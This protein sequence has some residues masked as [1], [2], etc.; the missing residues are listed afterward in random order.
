VLHTS[1]S[2]MECFAACPFKFFVDSGLRAEER[3]LFELDVKEQ[4][5][6]QH[7]VLA[8]FHEQLRRENKRWRDINPQTARDLIAQIARGLIVSYRDGLMQQSEES[9][10]T[11]RIL[12]ES[13]QDFAE[14]LVGWM[15]HQYQFDPAEVEL[16]FGGDEESPAWRIGLKNGRELALYGRID[17]VDLWQQPNGQEAL[18]VVVDYKSSRKLLDPVLMAHGIQLQLLAYLNVL[19][20]W[21][22]PR[23][24][25]GVDRLLPA[26]VFY[27][28]LKG[29]YRSARHRS[30]ALNDPAST[31]KLAYRH[32]GRFDI[33]ALPHLDGRPNVTEGDQFNYRLTS[34][35]EVY[36]SCQDPVPPAEFQ[37]MLNSVEA[38]L[39]KMGQK[40]FSGHAE[41][42]PYSKGKMTACN[43]CNYLSICRIDPWT[44]TYRVLN[45]IEEAEDS[46]KEES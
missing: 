8:C 4:G 16:P 23:P 14:T 31:R 27:V 17:R 10:F 19:R 36:K 6:F 25:F 9:R 33:R 26:G 44:H 45:K 39:K 34:V 30:E 29:K 32:V 20:H 3:K 2:R 35:G 18:C 24:L 22:D 43:Q 46:E 38:N 13:L 15:Q 42:A 1:V 5:S 11:A 41:V 28:N 21:P 12:T 37:A 40:I 7:D